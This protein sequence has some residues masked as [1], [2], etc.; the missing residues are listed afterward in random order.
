[1]TTELLCIFTFFIVFC[2]IYHIIRFFVEAFLGNQRQHLKGLEVEKNELWHGRN[3][4][5]F[6]KTLSFRG[7]KNYHPT[8][9]I[10][11]T[12]NIVTI[13]S[14]SFLSLSV[15]GMSLIK[16]EEKENKNVPDNLSLDIFAFF[17]FFRF[18][19]QKSSLT[20][21]LDELKFNLFFPS[22]FLDEYRTSGPLRKDSS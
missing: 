15:D 8:L 22:S 1:M 17:F 5:A 4:N 19:S 12:D 14:K 9:P 18:Q 11:Q 10:S 6:P 7:K 2:P 16:S 21:K 20:A 3:R 13:A